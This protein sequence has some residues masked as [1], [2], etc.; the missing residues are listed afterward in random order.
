[1]PALGRKQPAV[2]SFPQHP[3]KMEQSGRL[4]NDAGTENACLAH[5]KSAQAGE[6]TIRR[7]QVGRTLATT[8]E[9]QQLIPDQGRFGDDRTE[10][11]RPRQSGQSDDHMNE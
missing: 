5:E 7:A 1:M 4:Q 3:V 2:L 11:A 9:E 6:D 8:I 10:S